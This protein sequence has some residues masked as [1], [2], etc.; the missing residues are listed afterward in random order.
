[1]V[2]CLYGQIWPAKTLPIKAE[3]SV[4]TLWRDW[5]GLIGLTRR[6]RVER[7]NV[8]LIGVSSFKAVM[9]VTKSAIVLC[10]RLT[11]TNLGLVAGAR[12]NLGLVASALRC[13]CLR[14]L[15]ILNCNN[16]CTV[17]FP[18]LECR[19]FGPSHFLGLETIS[20]DFR[21]T[22]SGNSMMS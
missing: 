8:P 9:L 10:C 15:R 6:V 21:F 17:E 5:S 13:V 16:L 1:M 2:F 4:F 18:A 12:T 14:R 11:R 7:P 20:D 22:S 3:P 19:P